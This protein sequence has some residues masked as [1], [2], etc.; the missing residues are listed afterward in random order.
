MAGFVGADLWHSWEDRKPGPDLC[1]LGL[2]AG[3]KVGARG[4]PLGHLASCSAGHTPC[5]P[6]RALCQHI[7]QRAAPFS[8][9]A[10][11]KWLGEVRSVLVSGR[12]RLL[13]LCVHY[14]QHLIV[15][16][17]KYVCS[18]SGYSSVYSVRCAGP[19]LGVLVQ[20]QDTGD[21]VRGA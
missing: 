20:Y 6:G 21:N 15:V 19:I 14:H 1:A 4:K 10:D 13:S 5:S 18:L 9:C 17:E 12:T 2:E 8:P 7:V 3:R 16:E 11:Q